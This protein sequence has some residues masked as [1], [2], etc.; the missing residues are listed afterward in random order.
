MDFYSKIRTILEN[1]DSTIKTFMYPN[2]RYESE[3]GNFKAFPV[4]I[5]STDIGGSGENTANGTQKDTV[6]YTVRFMTNDKRDAFDA[7]NYSGQISQDSYS[8][9]LEMQTLGNSVLKKFQSENLFKEKPNWSYRLIFKETS[10]VLTGC[11]F[12]ISF[13]TNAELICS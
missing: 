9:A 13:S 5:I 10:N 7:E 12:D 4:C 1:Y 3:T 6:S 8:K 2:S 11:S